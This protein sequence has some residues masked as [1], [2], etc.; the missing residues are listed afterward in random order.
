[1]GGDGGGL[2][3]EPRHERG[4]G[5]GLGREHLQQDDPPRGVVALVDDGGL[6]ARQLG[7]GPDARYG[8]VAGDGRGGVPERRRAGSL[9]NSPRACAPAFS[10]A[11]ALTPPPPPTP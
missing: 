2:A 3:L 11:C 8:R 6:A 4:V 5:G 7:E 10:R 9:T 1:D